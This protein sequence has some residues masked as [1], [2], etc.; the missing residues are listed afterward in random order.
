MGGAVGR[1]AGGCDW[2]AGDADCCDWPRFTRGRVGGGPAWVRGGGG[3]GDVSVCVCVCVC[4]KGVASYCVACVH[5]HDQE[6]QQRYDPTV[7][8]MHECR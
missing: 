8:F 1:A 7:T 6:D 2:G 5:T 3:C 4:V